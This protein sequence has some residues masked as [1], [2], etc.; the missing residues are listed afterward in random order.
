MASVRLTL[1][2]PGSQPLSRDRSRRMTI[3]KTNNI[4]QT[5]RLPT[6]A[7]TQNSAANNNSWGL[8]PGL[9]LE[10]TLQLGFQNFGGFPELSSHSK[11]DAY[12]SFITDF[13]FDIF[14]VSE[15][16]LN[17]GALSAESQFQERIR[18]TWE[19]THSCLAYNHTAPSSRSRQ[20]TKGQSQFLQYGGVALLTTTQASHRVSGSGRDP[21]GLG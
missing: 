9:K 20:K 8:S 16:N 11:N 2:L 18:N 19:K 17:W 10:D 12:R 6:P 21:T 13:D 7:T 15:T 4:L 5:S 3:S 1:A 14:G